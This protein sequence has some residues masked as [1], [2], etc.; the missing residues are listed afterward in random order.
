MSI[1]IYGPQG[2]GKTKNAEKLREYFEC[3]SVIDGA[4]PTH[5]RN[6]NVLY[7][8][9]GNISD[10]VKFNHSVIPYEDAMYCLNNDK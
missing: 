5:Y 8:T 9:N 10:S 6:D 3:D 1:V 4:F 7:L 2:C